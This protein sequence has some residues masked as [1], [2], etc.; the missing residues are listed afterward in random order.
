VDF[1][2]MSEITTEQVIAAALKALADGS[3]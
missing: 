1:R 3:C 2:C